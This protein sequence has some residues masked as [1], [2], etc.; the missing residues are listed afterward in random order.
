MSEEATKTFEANITKLGDEI[1]EITFASRAAAGGLVAAEDAD[2]AYDGIGPSIMCANADLQR[3]AVSGA[4]RGHRWADARAERIH[5]KSRLKRTKSLS[6][7]RR[8]ISKRITKC[9]IMIKSSTL[10]P[11]PDILTIAGEVHFPH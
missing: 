3:F 1:A 5:Y 10:C 11:D 2:G 8:S 6:R 4:G 9:S 7:K